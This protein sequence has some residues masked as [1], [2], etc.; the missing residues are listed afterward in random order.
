M[1]TNHREHGLH[2]TINPEKVGSP[3]GVYLGKSAKKNTFSLATAKK[4]S[5]YSKVAV[6]MPIAFVEQGQWQGHGKPASGYNG[7]AIKTCCSSCSS[8][9]VPF[10]EVLS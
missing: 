7:Y 4:F 9:L 2:G 8:T 1:T 6:I 10:I 5:D 3:E